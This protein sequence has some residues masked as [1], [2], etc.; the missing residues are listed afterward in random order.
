MRVV[1]IIQARMGSTR[2]P[3]KVLEDI[4][5]HSMLNRVVRRTRQANRLD[6]VLIATSTAAQD[7]AVALECRQI[8][9][10]CFRGSEQDVLDRYF[11][12]A[13]AARAEVVVRVTSDCPLIDGSLIDRVVATFCDQRPDYASNF[14]QRTYPRG[15]DNEAFHFEGLAR[16]WCEAEAPYQRVHVT[17][18]FYEHPECFRLLAVTHDTDLSEGRWTVDTPDDLRFVRSVYDC[19][20]GSDRFTWH[21]VLALLA[22]QPSMASINAHIRQKHLR[23]ETLTPESGPA[24]IAR[25]KQ[26]QPITAES[27]RSPLSSADRRA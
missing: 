26:A 22:Q 21:D 2:L 16:A 19:F 7:D 3:G 1:A 20:G 5:G 12:A 27:A 9:V 14:L 6:D 11:A 8:G 18:Y 25:L 4:H 13:E 15:L 17:P 10:P 23:D 24:A